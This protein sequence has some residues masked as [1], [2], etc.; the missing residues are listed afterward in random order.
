M[1]ILII[2]LIIILIFGV[3]AMKNLA[4]LAIKAVLIG[5]ILLGGLILLKQVGFFQNESPGQK[6]DRYIDEYEY[7]YRY[8]RL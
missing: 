6:L 1:S 5:A 7:E 8:R 2:A 3:S 4:S